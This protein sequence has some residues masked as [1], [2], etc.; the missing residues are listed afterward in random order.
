MQ[1]YQEEFQGLIRQIENILEEDLRRQLKMKSEIFQRQEHEIL[2]L[3]SLVKVNDELIT[4][5]KFGK[6]SMILDH[7]FSH[8]RYPHDRIGIGFDKSQKDSEEGERPPPS[9]EKI[10]EK[11]RSHKDNREKFHDQQGSRR[12]QSTKRSML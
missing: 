2:S 11:S 8:Q 3:K 6:G 5:S 7:I 4:K 12:T 10:E 9:Q 1:K